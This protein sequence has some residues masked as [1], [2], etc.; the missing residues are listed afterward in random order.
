M[1]KNEKIYENS[2]NGE[3]VTVSSIYSNQNGV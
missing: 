2:N 3:I 1:L